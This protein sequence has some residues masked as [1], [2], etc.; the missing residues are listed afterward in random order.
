MI[1]A[2]NFTSAVPG[3]AYPIYQVKDLGLSNLQISLLPLSRSVVWLA[4]HSL[5]GVV[6]DRAKPGAV[7]MA[8]VALYAVAPLLGAALIP[9]YGVRSVLLLGEKNSRGRLERHKCRIIPR[10]DLTLLNENELR[11]YFAAQ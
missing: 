2:Y 9:H 5:W 6:S 3:P 11:W 4:T 8:G 10:Q 7:I 1:L